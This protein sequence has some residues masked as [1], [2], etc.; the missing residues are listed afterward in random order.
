MPS[1]HDI[2]FPRLSRAQID[3]LRRWGHVRAIAPG[4]V[5]F[6]EGDRGFSFYVVLEGAVEIVEQSRGTPRE[7]TVHEPGE[8]ISKRSA[9]ATMPGER[10]GSKRRRCF[11]SS[12]RSAHRMAEWLR[13]A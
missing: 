12:G 3:A 1:D 2:A 8:V 7:V 11:S 6:Q 10:C 4:D 9:S 5:L 13:A